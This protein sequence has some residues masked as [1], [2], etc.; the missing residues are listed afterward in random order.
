MSQTFRL[1]VNGAVRTVTADGDTPL[2]Y[3]LRNDLGLNG[4]R[5]GCGLGQCGACSVL[6]G[7][8]PVRSCST[9]LSAVQDAAVVTLEGLGS[10]DKPHPLQTAF[11]A[12]QAAQCGYCSNGMIMTAK[13]LLDENPHPKPEQV[14]QALSGNLCRCGTHTRIVRAVLRAAD[15]LQS[16]KV[17]P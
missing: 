1:S 10:I 3:V 13:S 5:F 16:A 17:T 2:L 11:I 7:N 12:E 8:V 6:I 4:P 9:P 15:H 14:R